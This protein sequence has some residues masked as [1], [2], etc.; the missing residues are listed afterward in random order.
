L[1][2]KVTD[3]SG[4][5][6]A[7]VTVTAKVADPNVPANSACNDG[8]VYSLPNTGPDGVSSVAAMFETYSVTATLCATSVTVTVQVAPTK[9]IVTYPPSTSP[10]VVP[11]PGPVAVPL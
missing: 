4:N 5:P 2:I 1:P 9:A 10:N 3:L 11:L 6:L 8:V 7:G